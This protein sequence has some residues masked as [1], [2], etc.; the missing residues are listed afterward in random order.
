MTGR[1]TLEKIDADE[2]WRIY[3]RACR[4]VLRMSG[5]EFARRWDA[6]EF[7]GETTPEMMEVLVLR[8]RG[9]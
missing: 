8:P 7:V 3:D 5:V 6:G 4:R 1:V 9:R 2:Q